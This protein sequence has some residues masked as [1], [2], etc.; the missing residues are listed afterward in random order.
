[1]RPE[2]ACIV[3]TMVALATVGGARA[4]APASLENVPPHLRAAIGATAVRLPDGL[5][6]VTVP[7]GDTFTTHGP[8]PAHDHSL[9]M[10]P[11]DPERDPV[12]AT[13]YYQHVL[14]GRP[15][16]STD[17]LSS[18]RPQIVSAIRR[19]NAVLNEDSLESG[20][21]TADYKVLCNENGTIRIDSFTS[22][23]N[24]FQ[25]IVTSAQTAGYLASN[26][27]YS[28]FYDANGGNICG[29]ASFSRDESLS[30]NNANNTGRDYAVTYEPCWDGRTPMHENGHN[31]GAVQASAPDSTGSGGH[32]NDDY[33][34][35]CYS[36]DGGDKNQGGTVLRCLDRIHF[37]CDHDS[38]FDARPEEGEYLASNWNIGSTLNRFIVFGTD[39]GGGENEAPTVAFT[40]S[41]EETTCSYVDGSS[42]PDGWIASREWTFGDG[43]TA[44]DAGPVHTYAATGV[45]DVRLTVTD[46]RG[47]GSSLTKT[48]ITPTT[49]AITQPAEGATL[50]GPTIGIA[51][52]GPPQATITVTLNGATAGSALAD[53][54]GS[55]SMQLNVLGGTY[56][57]VARASTST[58]TSPASGTR[59]FVVTDPPEVIP[60]IEMPSDGG[61]TWPTPTITGVAEGAA[62]VQI[63]L[64]GRVVV[65]RRPVDTSGRFSE[66]ISTGGGW[67]TVVV[68]AEGSSG[69]IIGSSQPVSFEVDAVRPELEIRSGDLFALSPVAIDGVA[70]D[71]RE[72]DRV[73]VRATNQATGT[74]TPRIEATLDPAGSDGW[75]PWAA[76]IE[77]LLPGRYVIEAWA[78]DSV[79][80]RSLVGSQPILVL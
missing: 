79:G 30:E 4:D 31:Q 19:M 78:Y 34:V 13:D 6:R 25:S 63:R 2:K 70:R 50:T 51:G 73:E 76:T 9:S 77:G 75:T 53:A 21:P 1:M 26:A 14:Y 66:V 20:G 65:T 44:T 12:C 54:G 8:D 27:D 41:C 28:I 48:I 47:A 64:D 61:L 42:D 33:D 22:T 16:G 56:A 80:L 46:D 35:M 74:P 58:G 5:Y 17:R 29:I 71:D 55:W 3:V 43:A 62:R 69:L 49:P 11:G 24:D 72:L 18:V 67:H 37:D 40:V 15:S 60:V 39:G 10:G 36:P 57:A 7:S 45:Y 52:T 23:A 59:N 32:C 68:D 38:Y